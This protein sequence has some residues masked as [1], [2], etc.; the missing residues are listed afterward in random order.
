MARRFKIRAPSVIG[1]RKRGGI[2]PAR[3]QTLQAMA[4]TQSDIAAALVAAGFPL[5]EREAA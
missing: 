1:W 5:A 4:V 3:L 2:P